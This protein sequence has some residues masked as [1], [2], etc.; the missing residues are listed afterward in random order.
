MKLKGAIKVTAAMP[1]TNKP[2][3]SQ[4]KLDKLRA[5]NPALQTLINLFDLE[6]NLE[7]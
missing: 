1:K 2:L 4:Q 6:S 7:V 3:T 5:K